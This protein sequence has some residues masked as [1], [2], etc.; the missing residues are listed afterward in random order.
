[1]TRTT[2]AAL[3]LVAVGSVA[4]G[5]SAQQGLE[6][7]ILSVRTDLVR[8]SVTV[9][10]RHGAVV[11]GLHREHFTVYDSGEP[12]TI[13]LFTS[14][15][16]PATVGLIVD[17]SGSMRGR[18]DEMMEVTAAF[19]AMARPLDELFT[20][21]FN[22]AVW[23]GLPPRLAFTAD[24][25]QLRAAM[26]DAVPQGTTALY[27]AVDRGLQHLQSGTHDRKALI[28]F[29]DGGDNASRHT[30]GDVLDRA[31][32]TTAVVYSVTLFDPDN[33]DERPQVLK[34]L[35]RETGGRVFT[36]K[37][38]EE[39]T[40]SVAEIAQ[41][42]RSGYTVGFVPPETSES[43]FRPIRVVVDAGTG[44]QFTARTRA[45]YYAERSDEPAR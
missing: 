45:G 26:E 32:R 12:R 24:P 36:A 6:R 23:P 17:S 9:V 35:T 16:L 33:R 31:R 21:Y 19:A 41:E 15:E 37:R 10:D 3:L 1:M 13:Q 4:D 7:L 40:R 30:F 27:D 11:T 8:L 22:E 34:A 2:Y 42:I 44:T 38:L 28:V 39:L 5:S 29:S 14:E 43:G 20:L 18:R 25:L